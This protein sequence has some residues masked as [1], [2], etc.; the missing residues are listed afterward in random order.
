MA[1]FPF[2]LTL[3]IKFSI[4]HSLSINISAREA[5]SRAILPIFM[6]EICLRS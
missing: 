4:I 6:P 2:L 1:V 3:K 5:E